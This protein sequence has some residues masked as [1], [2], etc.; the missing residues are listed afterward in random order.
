[1][2]GGQHL[3][4]KYN[5]IFQFVMVVPHYKEV[6]YMGTRI[7]GDIRPGARS[8]SRTA[9]HK[10][11]TEKIRVETALEASKQNATKD[12]ARTGSLQAFGHMEWEHLL[13]H[14]L[15]QDPHFVEAFEWHFWSHMCPQKSGRSQVRPHSCSSPHVPHL[16]DTLVLSHCKFLSASL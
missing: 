11:H 2:K 4:Y 1:V 5:K 8:A 10:R 12:G 9:Q 3:Y 16:Y 14:G 13:M 15:S 6:E 7:Q